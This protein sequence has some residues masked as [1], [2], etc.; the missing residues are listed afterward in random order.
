MKVV[1]V[2]GGKMGLPL[3]CQFAKNGATVTVCDINPR[4]V[5]AINSGIPPFTEPGLEELLK[6]GMQSGRLRAHTDT[7]AAVRDAEVVIIIV[8]ALLTPERNADLSNL[9]A[10][11]RVV[12][13]GLQPD[14]LV[15]YETTV[16]LGAC[17]HE[18]IPLLEEG[19]LKAGRD[20][21]VCFSPERV[22][23]LKVFEAL[24]RTPKVVGGLDVHSAKRGSAFYR[25]YLKTEILNVG[26]LESAEMVKLAG[27]L[28][29]DLNIALANEIAALCEKQGL[30][31][32]DIIAAA[33]TDGETY[34]LQPGIGVGGHCTPV[35][36][37]FLITPAETKGEPLD[38]F[39][40]GR[41]I[42]EKQPARNIRRLGAALGSLHG[43]RIHIL[44]LA[45]RPGVKEHAY[46]TAFALRDE[47]ARQ[48]AIIT[49][50]D[51][52]YSDEEIR[53]LGFVP[54]KAGKDAME[55]VILNTGHPV[56]AAADFTNW[57]GVQVVL[58]GRNFWN[59]AAQAIISRA[60]CLYLCV[61]RG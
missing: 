33:N 31:A 37:Y 57:Q 11:S 30:D 12:A 54:A 14:T 2:G 19:G 15:C 16:P 38:F 18:L 36:P 56:W 59:L 45:F 29:R 42:N 17:R 35:Y 24:S 4:L 48:G 8:P 61:G 41:Q 10:A 53:A 51:P 47:L 52:L 39:K 23:S 9:E 46:S 34:L 6:V 27:M 20:F 26:T 49:L 3:A 28:Y 44:G 7:T 25:H 40:C 1:V 32:Y 21:S 50:E 22:K 55:A 58:D 5:A 60:G 13:M 43:R